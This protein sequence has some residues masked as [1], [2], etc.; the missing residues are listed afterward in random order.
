MARFTCVMVMLRF[1]VMGSGYFVF[2]MSL[3]SAAGGGGKKIFFS[4]FVFCSFVAAS[5]SNVGMKVLMGVV[6]RYLLTFQM[7]YSSASLTNFCH[8]SCLHLFISRLNIRRCSFHSSSS[9]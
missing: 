7:S 6:L 9:S 1:V 2:G 5:P 8:V 4:V 3:R